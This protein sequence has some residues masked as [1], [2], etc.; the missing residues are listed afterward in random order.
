MGRVSGAWGVRGWLR[1]RSDCEPAEQ[2][3]DY[4]TW[5]LKTAEGWRSHALEAGRTHGTGLVVKLA[6]IDDRERARALAGADIAVERSALPALAEGEYYWADL[7][8]LAV[9]TRDGRALGRVSGLM[10]TGANDVLVV[11]G[12]RERLVPFIDGQ[13]VLEVDLRMRRI[14]VDWDPAF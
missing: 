10:A 1:V 8:G 3:L 2:L 4:S 14:E 7:I 12:D 5:R 9:V 13:V 6:A 11:D